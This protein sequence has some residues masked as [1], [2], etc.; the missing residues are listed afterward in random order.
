MKS[1]YTCAI[2]MSISHNVVNTL[3]AHFEIQSSGTSTVSH[4]AVSNNN[5]ALYSLVHQLLLLV[6]KNRFD[7]DSRGV[8]GK[9]F[10]IY[11]NKN[12]N[13]YYYYLVQSGCYPVAV[14]ILHVNKT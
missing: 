8:G 2:Q 4:R 12:N 14:V 7:H 1:R 3:N 5:A 11:N 10:D 6:H 9:Q 13:Y